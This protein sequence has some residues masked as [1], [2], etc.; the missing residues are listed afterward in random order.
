MS[1][2]RVRADRDDAPRGG[3]RDRAAREGSGVFAG[4]GV[5]RGGASRSGA[6]RDGAGRDGFGRDGAVRTAER[7]VPGRDDA[8]RDGIGRYDGGWDAAARD[9]ARSGR[10][11][12]GRGADRGW[13]GFGQADRDDRG[14]RNSGQHQDRRA[15][16]SRDYDSRDFD[17]S[18]DS[19]IP[20]S[21][22]TG[23]GSAG[24]SGPRSADLDDLP[25][26]RDYGRGQDG[27]SAGGRDGAAMQIAGRDGGAS[28]DERDRRGNAGPNA[29]PDGRKGAASQVDRDD[30]LPEV[31]PRPGKGTS[32]GKSKRD[33]DGDWPST[34]W[35]EL[36]DVDYWA[37]LAS[38]KP[39]T[40]SPP[41]SSALP[42]RAD[43]ERDRGDARDEPDTGP[44]R[45]DRRDRPERR[46]IGERRDTGDRR[47]PAERR[48]NSERRDQSLLP[49]ARATGQTVDAAFIPASSDPADATLG[50]RAQAYGST[51]LRRAI[52]AGGEPLRAM[53]SGRTSTTGGGRVPQPLDDDPLTSPSFPRVSADDSRSYRRSRTDT[54]PGGRPE[55]QTRPNP[56]YQNGPIHPPVSPL[57]SQPGLGRNSGGYS[58]PAAP[59][60]PS[61]PVAAG[62]EYAAAPPASVD[63]YRQPGSQV[64]GS[65]SAR[66]SADTGG[67]LPPVGGSYATDAVTA[68]YSS[69]MPSSPGYSPLPPVTHGYQASDSAIYSAPVPSQPQ[70]QPMHSQPMPSQPATS[71]G[72]YP[73]D[74][75]SSPYY[76]A[77]QLPEP[78]NYPGYSTDPGRGQSAV[79]QQPSGFSYS[80]PAD[81]GAAG[82]LPAGQSSASY[83]SYQPQ[84]HTDRAGIYQ[85]PG[86]Q[87]LPS[88][89]GGF[90]RDFGGPSLQQVQPGHPTAPYTSA[91]YEPA[92][93]A[94]RAYEVDPYPADPYAVDPYG[95]P[96][97]GAGAAR[98]PEQAGRGQRLPDPA[99]SRPLPV[100][101]LPHQPLASQPR[102]ED[103][104]YDES[105]DDRP[106]YRRR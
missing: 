37:E 7:R 47:D 20:A 36:S 69:P 2:P 11:G 32:P 9:G 99:P 10:D 104:W 84:V 31:R 85:V 63:P 97:Y 81:F 39:L 62:A 66:P 21:A 4:A 103:E 94:T 78:A 53:T 44:T 22:G 72:N 48:E 30:S 90:G 73:G 93:Y 95:Y 25:G 42:G 12:T 74:R 57:D 27:R 17:D 16:G 65:Y 64:S 86:S 96:G 70:S 92:G 59:P 28:R 1:R 56:G 43:R 61:P 51:E 14:G 105:W 13:D 18:A 50:G 41:P 80:D 29:R 33:G 24:R 82:H 35:D 67:Y 91:P 75:D 3:G 15:P 71:A 34:E 106:W 101:L 88:A 79:T 8:G 102:Y 19:L 40:A 68:A 55:S 26:R 89:G 23:R 46:D 45:A 38:D 87:P 83:L 98:L 60:A 52:A 49:A 6:G 54:G 76:P 58:V 100:P 5:G 77:A